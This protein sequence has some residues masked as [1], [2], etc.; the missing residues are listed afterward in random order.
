MNTASSNPTPRQPRRSPTTG[1][2]LVG[3][4]ALL[5]VGAILAASALSAQS[6]ATVRPAD[7]GSL[8]D[9]PAVGATSAR[10]IVQE[11]SDFQC[12]YCL[13]F[14]TAVEA[15]LLEQYVRTG[16][17]R[18]EYHHFVIIDQHTG[19]HESERAAEA[20]TCAS[21]QGKFWRYH[22]TL[23]AHQA[24][25]GS[26]AFSDA[27][28]AGFAETVG[29]DMAAFNQCL[30]STQPAQAVQTDMARGVGLGVHGTPTVFINGIQA[31]N[32]YDFGSV[33]QMVEAALAQTS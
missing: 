27:R 21:N 3:G 25:E 22:D 10:V 6:A 28:L 33:Q 9:G 13:R 17:V 1:L 15:Q 5:V 30:A 2:I 26:G 31:P 4:L 14:H 24:G 11:F 18:F 23:F 20:S 12:P 8:E 32:P 19:G 7:L 16:K 29:L